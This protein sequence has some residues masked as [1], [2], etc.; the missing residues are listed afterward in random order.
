MNCSRTHTIM[1]Q[2]LGLSFMG[3]NSY[4]V[5]I[6]SPA[7]P[8]CS[9]LLLMQQQSENRTGLSQFHCTHGDYLQVWIGCR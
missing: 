7:F 9:P 2:L 8:I 1:H 4:L 6:S 5:F 3:E